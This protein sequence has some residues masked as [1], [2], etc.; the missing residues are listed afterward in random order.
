MDCEE[1]EIRSRDGLTLRGK[2]YEYEK[3][4]PLEIMFHGYRGNAARNLSGG[5]ERC[6]TLKR[7]TLIVSQRAHGNSEG[8][9]ITFGY[10]EKYD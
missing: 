5:V 6:F 2:Y 4:A 9:V 7:N 3:G 10:K 1:V 8:H